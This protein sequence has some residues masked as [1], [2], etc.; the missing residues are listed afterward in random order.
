MFS[1]E[2]KKT[3]ILQLEKDLRTHVEVMAKQ[4]RERKQEL[5]A[6]QERDWDLCELLCASPYRI[7]ADVVPSLEELDRFRRHLLALAAEKVGGVG[8]S[9]GRGNWTAGSVAHILLC[10]LGAP[11]S[12]VCQYKETDC[13][14]YE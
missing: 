3:T 14:L 4:K 9:I 7:D 1:Q 13:P 11:A 12:G 6:L 8:T 2:D 5:K 10:F